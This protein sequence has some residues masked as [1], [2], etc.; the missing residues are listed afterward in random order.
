MNTKK[1]VLSALFIAIG[2]LLP[3]FF[4][5][6][7]VSSRVF[8][9]MHIPI[10][11]CG[12]LMGPTYGLC[13]GIAIPLLSSLLTGMPPLL[14]ILPLMLIELAVYGFTAGACHHRLHLNLIG[15]LIAAM[16]A[17]RIANTIAIFLLAQSLGISMPPLA[18]A[19][20]G[21]TGGLI[22]IAIQ[23]ALIPLLVG[24]INKSL[25]TNFFK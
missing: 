3:V 14:P 2:I 5:S 9:P 24:R 13:V 18:Y 11:M 20:N 23:L 6:M 1:T 16:I 15:S 7:G 19:I 21:I 12:L 10:L 25:G 22:G 4:H 8:L 17:G